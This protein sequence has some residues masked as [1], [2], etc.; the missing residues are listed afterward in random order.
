M[1][2]Q[3]NGKKLRIAI[4]CDPVTDFKAGSL[5]SAL[6]YAEILS[7]KGHTVM[8]I[9]ARSKEH[10][11]DDYYGNIRM[12]RFF[13]FVPPKFEKGFSMCFPSIGQLKKIFK[14]EKI[15]IVHIMIPHP[16]AIIA[17]RVANTLGIPLVV[18]SHTQPENLFLHLPKFKGQA[19]LNR[20]FYAYLTWLYKK[21]DALVYPTEFAK[22]FFPGLNRIMRHAVI[23]NG[24]DTRMFKK[25]DP[26]DFLQSFNISHDAAKILY[27]GRLHPEKNIPTLLYA[28]PHIIKKEPRAH[29]ML[30]GSGILK[31]ELETIV[32]TLKIQEHVTFLGKVSDN[33]LVRAYNSCDIFVLPSLAELEGM[34][35][36]EAM[37]CGKPVL[38]ADSPMSA[39]PS[40][41]DG[42]GL[43]FIAQ[44]PVH[45]SE[46]ALYILENEKVHV[47]MSQ[48][49]LEKAARHDLRACVTRLEDLY[50]T[51]LKK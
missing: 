19:I 36:L 49:S 20:W 44:D 10:P 31:E 34:V 50:F 38:V 4:V 1:E 47:N 28:M 21:A 42:N 8:F 17:A 51:I 13:S 46:Q 39:A 7:E 25:M 6:R 11:H 24:V 48:K 45:L 35:V 29:L 12:Y 27:V 23:S 33:D 43:T 3:R 16:S 26:G 5:V 2:Q 32:R 22:G 40:L 18:H 41:I 30:V 9:A 14:E 37:A 15:D